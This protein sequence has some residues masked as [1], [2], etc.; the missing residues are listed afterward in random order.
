MLRAELAKPQFMTTTS[1]RA[2]TEG[3]MKYSLEFSFVGRRGAEADRA[4]Q[5]RDDLHDAITA[6]A[7]EA[8]AQTVEQELQNP[9]G[10][11]IRADLGSAMAPV[12]VTGDQP[13]GTGATSTAEGGEPT[14]ADIAQVR[15]PSDDRREDLKAAFVAGCCAVLT[16]TNSGM[17]Q[18]D[19]DEAGYDY[20]ASVVSAAPAPPTGQEWQTIDS[21]PKDGTRV[22][23]LDKHGEITIG[24]WETGRE[25]SGSDHYNDWSSGAISAGGYDAGFDRVYYVTHWRPLPSPPVPA[26]G[27]TP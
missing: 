19:L 22:L 15:T 10:E 9:A 1:G 13:V 2:A 24:W 11:T 14:R 17:P 5:R 20:A 23:L 6:Y 12:P 25:F 4:R 18:D 7:R 16:W 26:E 3:A 21:A 8:L 27:E